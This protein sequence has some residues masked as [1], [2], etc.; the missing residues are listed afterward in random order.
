MSKDD[1]SFTLKL[2]DGSTNIIFVGADTKVSKSVETT[3]GEIKVGAEI[4]VSGDKNS[5]GSYIAKTI[6][7][8]PSALPQANIQPAQKRQE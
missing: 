4:M 7:L 3:A 6:N 1:G 5:D 8:T 2:K